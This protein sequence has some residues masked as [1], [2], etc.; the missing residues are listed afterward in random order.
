MSDDHKQPDTDNDDKDFVLDVFLVVTATPD[1][2]RR[3][4]A[5]I[6]MLLRAGLE[7]NGE[8]SQ[9]KADETETEDGDR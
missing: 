4:A 7:T 8:C 1:A 9:S 2:R 3:L 6:E 5:A